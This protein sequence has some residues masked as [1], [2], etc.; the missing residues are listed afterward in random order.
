MHTYGAGS[1][2]YTGAFLAAAL[3]AVWIFYGFEACGDIA[4]EV[5]DPSRKIPKAMGW[6]LGI[7]GLATIILTLG[8]TVAVPDIGRP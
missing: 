5:R 4:E 8:L 3:F 2:D 1:G 6:T 7:G